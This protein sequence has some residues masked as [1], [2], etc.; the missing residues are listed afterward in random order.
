VGRKK[1]KKKIVITIKENIFH[2]HGNM[3]WEEN[4]KRKKQ[5]V[6]NSGGKPPKKRGDRSRYRRVRETEEKRK[7]VRQPRN[8][9]SS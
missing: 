3:T 9:E 7:G 2:S 1:N 6:F 8:Q 4:A 5:T